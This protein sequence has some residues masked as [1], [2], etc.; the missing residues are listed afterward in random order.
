MASRL[1][2]AAFLLTLS[3]PVWAQPPASTPCLR[4]AQVDSFKPLKGNDHAVLVRD[5]FR[6]TFK[7]GF[8]TSCDGLNFNMAIAI[9]T[10]GGSGLT[11]VGRGD[12]ILSHNFGGL[13]DRC[14]IDSITL[15]TPPHNMP[16]P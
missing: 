15:Y 5:K 1:L 13:S 16:A 14:I 2:T 9:H 11:C 4:P 7:L 10:L 3:G 12:Y 6:K 8:R